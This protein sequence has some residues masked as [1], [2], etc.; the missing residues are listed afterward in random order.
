[1]STQANSVGAEN[2][3]EGESLSLSPSL[4]LASVAV[5][6]AVW[7]LYSYRFYYQDD[8]FISL[9]YVH[10]LL[11][12]GEL[13]WNPG[14]R[15]EG[16][17][18]FLFVML[19]AALQSLGLEPMMS[20][21]VAGFSA[22]AF[23]AAAF[24]PAMRR[25]VPLDAALVGWA[26]AISSMPFL[27]WVWGGLEGPLF[28]ALVFALHACV[29]MALKQPRAW[30]WLPL[31]GVV[32]ALAVMTRQ[33]GAIFVVISGLVILLGS[34]SFRE[35]FFRA[36]RFA[37]CGAPFIIGFLA[38]R[39]AYYG[40]FLP[41]TYYVKASA[42]L[43]EGLKY[44]ALYAL[45]PPLLPILA[46]VAGVFGWRGRYRREVAY[47]GASAGLYALYV[48]SVGG[49]HMAQYRLLAPLAALFAMLVSFGASEVLPR[50]ARPLIP[51]A[52]LSTL[53]VL[54][55]F[56][57]TGKR[58]DQAAVM[59]TIVGQYIAEAWPPGALIAL[60]TA[61]ST[62]FY[63]PDKRFIDMLGLNDAVIARRDIPA[64]RLRR[65][66]WPGHNKGDGAYVLSRRPDYIILAAADGRDVSDP[67]F[68]SDIE[69][70]EN[71]KFLQCYAQNKVFIPYSYP[72]VDTVMPY[73]RTGPLTGPQKRI[74]LP[75]VYYKRK[76]RPECGRGGAK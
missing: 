59:G 21:R 8:A 51:A 48:A 4:L 22:L 54:Q 76:D 29:L 32:A 24:L 5:V 53:I 65:Q 74:L 6:M 12:H 25:F 26:F 67:W 69:L 63:N 72:E 13:A 20:T 37:A 43:L 42:N 50:I 28:G 56:V 47:L 17:T 55:S 15:V 2:R 7:I 41:N 23:I 14:E 36:F 18:N 1:M 45:Q 39:Y 27:V 34:G 16:F 19:T 73:D 9:R 33:D 49:D 38:F 58:W 68:L 46:L 3:R 30:Q 11:T 60:N 31:A 57:V 66:H 52:T 70:V 62:A 61:G 64:I 71:P 35:G 44:V 40:E 10:N 75:F